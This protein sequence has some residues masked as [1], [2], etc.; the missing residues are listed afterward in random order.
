MDTFEEKYS[1][2]LLEFG[3]GRKM[4]LSTAEKDRVTSRMMSIVQIDGLL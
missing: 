1:A 4:V 2:F 3:K